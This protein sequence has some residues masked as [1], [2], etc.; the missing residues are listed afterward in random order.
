MVQY[1]AAALPPSKHR[2]HRRT[3]HPPAR[4]SR[5]PTQ[6]HGWRKWKDLAHYHIAKTGTILE[7]WTQRYGGL[8]FRWPGEGVW[9][10]FNDAGRKWRAVILSLWRASPPPN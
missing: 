9:G 5:G 10:I 3:G 7:V 6:A 2:K 4:G 8:E 1:E